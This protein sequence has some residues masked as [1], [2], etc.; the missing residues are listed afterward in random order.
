MVLI[1]NITQIKVS[2][3]ES[4]TSLTSDSLATNLTN[5]LTFSHVFSSMC[6]RLVINCCNAIIISALMAKKIL[7]L[8]R[9]SLGYYFDV[10][11]ATI[12]CQKMSYF[13]LR[14]IL[15]LS[16]LQRPGW[17]CWS[18]F[19][20]FLTNFIVSGTMYTIFR[21]SDCSHF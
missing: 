20:N 2:A 4:C 5:S 12:L 9:S 19:C 21:S 16:F 8:K 1:C 14:P 18:N 17:G 6:S 7:F 3:M 13:H 10:L 15:C 11:S